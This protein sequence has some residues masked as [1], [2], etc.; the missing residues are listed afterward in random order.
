MRGCVI[1]FGSRG[2][3]E[4]H[5]V[6]GPLDIQNAHGGFQL[7]RTILRGSCVLSLHG[8]LERLHRIGT[9]SRERE[10]ETVAFRAGRSQVTLALYS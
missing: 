7:L 9:R 4:H 6:V 2:M 10:I 5:I 1:R 3:F 8:E